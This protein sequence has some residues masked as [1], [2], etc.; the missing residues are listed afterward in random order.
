MRVCMNTTVADA[1]TI[2]WL[3][4][5]E[6]IVLPYNTDCTPVLCVAPESTSAIAAEYFATT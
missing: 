3:N 2:A 1:T 5:G 4:P 6:S